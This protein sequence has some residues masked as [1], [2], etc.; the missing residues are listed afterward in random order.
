[1]SIQEFWLTTISQVLADMIFYGVPVLYAFIAW[2]L[3]A[4][5][6]RYKVRFVWFDERTKIGAYISLFFL[7]VLFLGSYV[8]W[9]H[10][11]AYSIRAL[12]PEEIGFALSML[13]VYQLDIIA[14]VGQVLRK[15]KEAKEAGDD[16]AVTSAV[17]NRLGIIVTRKEEGGSDG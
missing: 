5:F 8:T 6:R 15:R 13:A 9:A 10:M 12:S 7:T 14:K 16:N 11:F 17:F 3:I 2:R 1:M 4:F